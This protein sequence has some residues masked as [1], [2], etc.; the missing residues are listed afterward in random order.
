MRN[1][2]PFK[3]LNWPVTGADIEVPQTGFWDFV[4]NLAEGLTAPCDFAAEAADFFWT[5]EPAPIQIMRL[6]DVQ[7]MRE[8]WIAVGQYL[9]LAMDMLDQE[10]SES[11]K[12]RE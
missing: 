11:V 1:C 3:T 12:A 5:P 10:T 4:G 8:D 9:Q 6:G 2:S 7:A